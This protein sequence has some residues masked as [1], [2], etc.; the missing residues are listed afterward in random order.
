MARG[1]LGKRPGSG[2]EI[3]CVVSEAKAFQHA[4]QNGG[5]TVHIDRHTI[6]AQIG[7]DITIGRR[8]KLEQPERR[9]IPRLTNQG[10]T[11]SDDALRHAANANGVM[12]GNRPPM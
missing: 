2:I 6:A 10:R 9:I 1:S 11:R 7:G 3:G 4:A 12:P 8:P 5:D